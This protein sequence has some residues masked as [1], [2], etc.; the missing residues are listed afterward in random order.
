MN[1]L[2]ICSLNVRGLANDRKFRE[3]WQWLRNKKCSVYFLQETHSTES[4]ASF[5]RN[6]WGYEAV[7]SSCTSARAGVSILFNKNV[8]F[9]VLKQHSDPHGR[10]IVIDVSSNEKVIMLVN[11]YAPNHDD[12]EFFKK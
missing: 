2:T 7:F 8:C 6:E 3:T 11:L 12:P 5:W 4:R 10:F 9:Q 1:N